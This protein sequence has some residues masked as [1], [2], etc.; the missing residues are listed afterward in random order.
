MSLSE[1]EPVIKSP[2]GRMNVMPM[3]PGAHSKGSTL[4]TRCLLRARGL[5]GELDKARAVLAEAIK[6]RPEFS[7]LAR[8]R[9]YMTGVARSIGRCA[10]AR[11][12][13]ASAALVCPTSS[14]RRYRAGRSSSPRLIRRHNV[15]VMHSV[16][17]LMRTNHEHIITRLRNN[18]SAAVN[19][20]MP[21]LT[22]NPP[23]LTCYSP[24][25]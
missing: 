21:G 15:C 7:S 22:A 16:Q 3:R 10:S 13:S 17:G 5:K 2:S 12:L 1:C 23:A 20:A 11:Q 19:P 6:L 24:A 14:T 25:S 8:W 4:R 9:A 18:I